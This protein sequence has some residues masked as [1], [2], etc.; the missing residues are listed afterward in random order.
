MA[1]IRTTQA[2]IAVASLSLIGCA[3]VPK[4]TVSSVQTDQPMVLIEDQN[5]LRVER[6]VD[7]DAIRELQAL[8]L[9]R[10]QIAAGAYAEPISER[11]AQIVGNHAAR[12]L[13][14]ELA[15]YVRLTAEDT[16]GAG[17]ALIA[18]NAIQATGTGSAGLSS[19]LDFAV[20]GPF[21]LP[22]GLGALAADVEVRDAAGTQI[23]ISRW[24]RGANAITDAARLS[25]IGDAWQIA[26]QLGED[27]V[28][29]LLDQDVERSGT[30]RPKLD[31]AQ[32]TAN[33]E[34]CDRTYGTLRVAA[35]GAGFF[36]PMSPESM[37]PGPP[38]DPSYAQSE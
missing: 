11:Q 15:P 12:S 29:P 27:I 37:D 8:R 16:D 28:K 4:G 33:R 18:I 32:V 22:A 23:F 1:S 7:A 9:P 10:Y 25:S 3:S 20:P 2:C 30:Q 31:D 19:L 13:C 36:L 24:A 38:A 35:R 6:F 26:G 34:L 17:D 21:R 5:H 14:K